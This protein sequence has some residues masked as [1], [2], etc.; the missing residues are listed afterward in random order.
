MFVGHIIS[1]SL[2][3]CLWSIST[4][5][6][7][8]SRFSWSCWLPSHLCGSFVQKTPNFCWR[9]WHQKRFKR[10]LQKHKYEL[11]KP[12]DNQQCKQYTLHSRYIE[13]FLTTPDHCLTTKHSHIYILHY[14]HIYLYIYITYIYIRLFSS[15]S[16]ILRNSP[17]SRTFQSCGRCWRR[18]RRWSDGSDGS[19]SH[20]W[21]ETS[22]ITSQVWKKYVMHFLIFCLFSKF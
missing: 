1:M 18:P 8:I 11:G 20:V 10:I 16:E 2:S 3:I 7:S 19:G 17:H 21:S 9:Q 14:I 22:R 13:S 4:F 5:F 15:F 6:Q 12:I